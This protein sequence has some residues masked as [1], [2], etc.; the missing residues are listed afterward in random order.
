[1]IGDDSGFGGLQA[2]KM[3]FGHVLHVGGILEVPSQETGANMG[4]ERS[5]SVHGGLLSRGLLRRVLRLAL[6]EP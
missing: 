6:V 1:M 5:R 2:K 4:F 3:R